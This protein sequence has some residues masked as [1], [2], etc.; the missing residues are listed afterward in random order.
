MKRLTLGIVR[1]LIL[2]LI[3]SGCVR[4]RWLEVESGE[5]TQVRGT[6]EASRAV[7]R[8][9]R[10]LHV[11]REASTATL[12]LDDG[13]QVTLDFVARE[14]SEWPEGCPTN[15]IQHHLEV[16]DVEESNLS[17]ASMTFQEP[18]LVRNCPGDPPEIVLRE[19]GPIGGSGSA[20][21]DSCLVFAQAGSSSPEAAILGQWQGAGYAHLRAPDGSSLMFWYDNPGAA[22]CQTH[23]TPGDQLYRA[24]CSAQSATGQQIE[25][26]GTVGGSQA[27]VTIAGT[28][29]DLRQGRLFLI[30]THDGDP[31]MVQ[32]DRDLSAVEPVEEDVIAFAESVP[33][34]VRF[35]QQASTPP[36]ESPP[37]L[38]HSEKGYE[39]YSWTGQDGG[40][41]NYTLV[42]GTDRLKTAKEITESVEEDAL[43]DAGW[44][45]LTVSG[46][47]ALYDLLGRLPDGEQVFWRSQEPLL[48]EGATPGQF[49]L[50]QKPVVVGVLERARELGLRLTVDAQGTTTEPGQGEQPETDLEALLEVPHTLPDGERVPLTFT[51]INRSERSLFVLKWYTPLEGIAGEIFQ[52]RRDGQLLP[53]QGILAMRGDPAPQDYLHLAP[54]ASAEATVDLAQAYDFSQAGTYTIRFISPR[55]SH[56]APT[57]AD[58][59]GTVEDLGPVSMPSDPVTVTIG[60][61]E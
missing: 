10:S 37:P 1:I 50:P 33:E 34:I 36:N 18:V 9:V 5:Y 20:R 30:A 14:R 49:G 13:S 27:G 54:G 2:V 23:T 6:D 39:L 15:L 51:L 59:A 58:F 40:P 46:E 56:V 29:Y 11:D 19:N 32:L 41:W 7:A 45:K 4:D 22:R 21:S 53:Y 47:E 28:S 43:S 24:S 8:Q 57:E 26:E 48:P 38:P 31:S 60:T 61:G 16:L 55:I 42:T 44:V 3:L 35:V 52:V 17:I 25:W 12:A